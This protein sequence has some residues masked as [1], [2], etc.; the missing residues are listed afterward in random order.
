MNPSRISIVEFGSEPR[1]ASR[2]LS[3]SYLLGYLVGYF[4]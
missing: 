4:G 1:M 2:V 3:L